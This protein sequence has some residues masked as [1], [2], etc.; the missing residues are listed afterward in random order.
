MFHSRHPIPSS[1]FPCGDFVSDIILSRTS[2]REIFD[3]YDCVVF[4]FA[5]LPK[6]HHWFSIVVM[7]QNLLVREVLPSSLRF[8]PNPLR[9]P[10]P[11]FATKTFSLCGKLTRR[12]VWVWTTLSCG[13]WLGKK[14]SPTFA[15]APKNN[16]FRDPEYPPRRRGGQGEKGHRHPL[17]A[18]KRGERERRAQ[19]CR[20]CVWPGLLWCRPRLF[21]CRPRPFLR[22]GVWLR[23]ANFLHVPNRRGLC[24]ACGCVLSRVAARPGGKHVGDKCVR[25][26]FALAAPTPRSTP[27]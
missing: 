4:A 1:F 13:C 16:K 5:D 18:S 17:Q 23:A 7:C 2:T 9:V 25:E 12:F 3:G 11:T 22:W 26:V 20:V 21:G 15:P 10:R 27:R 14:K 6:N 8:A 19:S 24:V